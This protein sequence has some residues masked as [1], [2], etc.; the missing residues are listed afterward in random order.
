MIQDILLVLVCGLLPGPDGEDALKKEQARFEGVW[1]F[2]L[3]EVDGNK[4][5]VPPFDTN[6]LIILKD[7]R[8]VVLQGPRIT[9]GVMKL[10]PTQSPRH[11]DVVV[12]SPGKGQTIPAIYE[13]EG[14]TY[15]LCSSF[16][17]KGRPTAFETR[18]DSGMILQVLKREK[19]SVKEGLVQ[20][21]RQELAGTWQ[22]LTY[23]LDGK[24]A[25]EEDL[26]KIQLVIDAD[27]K[28]RALNEGKVFIASSITIDPSRQPMTMDIA[29]TEGESKGKT[30]LALYK[31]EDGVLTICRSAPGQA[32]PAEFASTEGSGHTLMSYRR[33]NPAPK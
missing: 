14:D 7:G 15:K 16:R 24:K 4:Q 3:V 1:S 5:P 6:K 26:K 18:A 30:A 27:G 13:L 10:D 23:S 19:Q 33:E 12:Q 25:S 20:A 9:R 28:S 8:F 31:I 32:R 21:G 2:A 11:L 22:A 29:F 17:G